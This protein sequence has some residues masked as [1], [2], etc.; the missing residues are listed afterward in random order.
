M[1]L[2][3]AP[4]PSP[5]ERKKQ[6]SDAVRERK[7]A[8]LR[9]VERKIELKKAQT[10][11]I[12]LAKLMMPAPEDPLDVT[13]TRYDAQP[14][15]IA[16][17][18]ALMEIESGQ[19]K[20]VII[21]MPPRHGKSELASKL[22]PALFAGRDPYRHVMV[23]SYN[24]PFAN[25][26]GKAVRKIMQ[27]KVFR[28]VFPEC[29]LEKGSQAVDRL[30]TEQGGV[31][32]FVGRGGSITG[33]GAH[34]FIIDDPL[35]NSK[36][37][38]SDLIRDELWTW[39][40]NDVLS[41]AMDDNARVIIIQTRW[42]EDDLVG[43]ITDPENPH[44]KAEEAAEWDIINI[45]ALCEDETSPIEKQLG[46]KNGD[47]LW[48]TKFRKSWL[49]GF[50]RRDG[51][52]FMALYQQR[53]TPIDG[54]FFKDEMIR[55]YDKRL[56][57]PD[58]VK[59]S[60]MRLKIYTSSDHATDEDQRNDYTVLL[61]VGVDENDVIWILDVRRGRWK[62]DVAVERMIDMWEKWRPITHY[63]EKEHIVKTIGPFLRKRMKERKVYVYLNDKVSAHSSDKEGKAQAIAGRMSMGMVMF[64]KMLSTFQAF[65]MEL[66]KFPRATHDDMVDA[67]SLIG[68]AL[69]KMLTGTTRPEDKK[70]PKA[71]TWAYFQAHRKQAEKSARKNLRGF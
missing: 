45:P 31:L 1:A 13:K 36:E 64:P 29:K 5:G 14:F 24:Q 68:R 60:G 70:Q 37:A 69:D 11:L 57:S 61:V 15:H 50:R 30:Q 65:R 27:S 52:G 42:H 12:T 51:R 47:A 20:K 4:T 22:F 34:L 40:N 43:R 26:F 63:A 16:L 41:R 38:D 46:R 3:Y 39:F 59:A 19:R 6:E 55:T 10:D 56:N 8:T 35:K 49:E 28:E 48:P 67:L 2:A 17:A 33:R 44:Y 62:S 25:D 71:G 9:A 66:L 54:D 21:C 53:P 18:K 23:G 7:L 58:L 32:A